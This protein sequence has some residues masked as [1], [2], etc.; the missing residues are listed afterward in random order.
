MAD[1]PA[2][3]PVTVAPGLWRWTAPHPAWRPGMDRPGGW[4]QEV[5]SLAY[6]PS[7]DQLILV[8][9][10]VEHW[11]PLDELAAGRRVSV[12]LTAPWHARSAAEAMQ[13]YGAPLYAH[14]RG[15]ERLAPL[16]VT[17]FAEAPWADAVEVRTLGG[18][19]DG[20]V[21]LWLPRVRAV[22]SA[23]ALT[24]SPEGLKIA[25]SPALLSRKE[26]Y[27]SLRALLMLPV[28]LVLPAHGA[29]VLRKGW[30]EISAAFKRPH[31]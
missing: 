7:E 22:V 31:H 9:P 19:D 27:E 28:E 13:R 2:R 17:S 5:A 24:G 25:E 16:A 30:D 15:S 8:D 14:E 1:D 6:A 10:L 20:E 12:L 21:L 23:E 11:E 3:A 18:V 4:E 26:L 29:P